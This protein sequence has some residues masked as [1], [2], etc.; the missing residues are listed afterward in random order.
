MQAPLHPGQTRPAERRASVQPVQL[1][2]MLGRLPLRR[3]LQWQRDAPQGDATAQ[4]GARCCL[5]YG[6]RP[7]AAGPLRCRLRCRCAVGVARREAASETRAAEHACCNRARR[8]APAPARAAA[9]ARVRGMECTLPGTPQEASGRPRLRPAAGLARRRQIHRP[10]AARRSSCPSPNP[11]SS[12]RTCGLWVSPRS[13]PPRADQRGCPRAPPHR[14]ARRTGHQRARGAATRRLP[15]TQHAGSPARP[16]R[17]RARGAA[18]ADAQAGRP[19]PVRRPLH[20]RRRATPRAPAERSRGAAPR[21]ARLRAL[22]GR[23]R[24]ARG[25]HDSASQDPLREGPPPR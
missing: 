24:Q 4:P 14:L 15:R 16:G 2:S 22:W 11:V 17:G 20:Q 10:C 19:A 23:C 13:A 12:P 18:A 5:G 3:V 6:V 25:P 7:T 8:S 21:E 9:R 1:Q